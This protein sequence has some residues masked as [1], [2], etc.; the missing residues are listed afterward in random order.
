MIADLL[1]VILLF[2]AFAACSAIDT[3]TTTDNDDERTR[4][5]VTL[6]LIVLLVY[7]AGRLG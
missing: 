2:G 3:A 7:I 6:T 1:S 4:L 5:R